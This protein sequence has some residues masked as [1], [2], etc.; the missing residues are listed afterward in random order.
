MKEAFQLWIKAL[1]DLTR[2][3][4]APVTLLAV[5][6]G[7]TRPRI[8]PAG[9]DLVLFIGFIFFSVVTAQI[10]HS[11]RSG[12]SLGSPYVAALPRLLPII[13]FWLLY[14]IITSVGFLLLL[15]PG[16]IWSVTLFW[17]DEFVVLHRMSPAQ[18]L[19]MSRRLVKGRWWR[20]LLFQW[21]AGLITGGVFVI[22]MVLFVFLMIPLQTLQP[23]AGSL[24]AL[25][26]GY[27]TF[28]LAGLYGYGHCL[29]V[30]YLYRLLSESPDL[31]K[32]IQGPAKPPPVSDRTA[33]GD[34]PRP[35]G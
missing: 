21:R 5:I 33:P 6:L 19:R 16:I 27:F 31:Q 32:E 22:F 11:H 30:N 28:V 29:Q 24:L 12:L 34:R 23:D 15:I 18:A 20:V 4:I 2:W 9:T 7:Y 25:A 1:P 8:E 3:V 10:T 26:M 14:M 35:T 17:G 13:V